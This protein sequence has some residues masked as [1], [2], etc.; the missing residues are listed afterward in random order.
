MLTWEIEN[1]FCTPELQVLCGCD[2]AGRGP[3]AG[4]VYAAAVILPKGLVIEGLDDSKKLSPKK[5]DLLYDRIKEQALAYAIARAE[6]EE[7]EELNILECALLAMR[8]AMEALE[9]RPD[10]ALIDGNIARGFSVPAFPVIGGDANCPSIA[11]ASVLAKVERDRDCLAL[12]KLYPQYGFA[13]HKGYATKAHRE[14]ILQ[15]GPCP[16][17]RMS[18][19]KKLLGKCE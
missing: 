18:F 3:L 6:V 15:Y 5:R 13:V 10:A 11:A 4:P 17:H 14:A 8:R 2:E 1:S 9:I 16:A 12:D 19:L 7:I